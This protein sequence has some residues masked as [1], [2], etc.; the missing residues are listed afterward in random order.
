MGL[1]YAEDGDSPHRPAG[2]KDRGGSSE[3]RAAALRCTGQGGKRTLSR[4]KTTGKEPDTRNLYD[5]CGTNT[6]QTPPAAAGTVSFHHLL[7][8]VLLPDLVIRPGDGWQEG[9]D[10]TKRT[11]QAP[12]SYYYHQTIEI[13]SAQS[14]AW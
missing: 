8:L 12:A 2:K 9:G 3:S 7:L 13:F 4:K 11:R 5:R 6:N 1:V 10:K 14:R